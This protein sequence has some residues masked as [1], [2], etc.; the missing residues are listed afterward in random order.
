MKIIITYLVQT[1]I[2][3]I[4]AGI[5]WAERPAYIDIDDVTIPESYEITNLGTAVTQI[6]TLNGYLADNIHYIFSRN[7]IPGELLGYDVDKGEISTQIVIK[8][9][10]DRSNAARS[11]VHIGDELF[12]GATF[13][14]NERRLSI[15][16]LNTATGEYYEA[17]KLHPAN[18]NPNR[19]TVFRLN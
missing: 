11:M 6:A 10:D 2:I 16:R 19:W 8:L 18:L 14:S 17:A 4:F 5:V 1:S 13:E 7:T 12:I 3:L 9:G 15:I